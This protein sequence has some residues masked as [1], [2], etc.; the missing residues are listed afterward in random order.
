MAALLAKLKVK[1]TLE[2]RYPVGIVMPTENVPP[3]IKAITENKIKDHTVSRKQ[4][5]KR[6]KTKIEKKLPATDKIVAERSSTVAPDYKPAPD[7]SNKKVVDTIAKVFEI[8]LPVKRKYKLILKPQDK[9]TPNLTVKERITVKP[10]D[11]VQSGPTSMIVI[12]DVPLKK[13]LPKKRE[14]IGIKVS[15]YYMNNREI[16]INFMSSLF[17]KYKD[18]ATAYREDATCDYD[19]NAPFSLMPHQKI[20]RDYINLITPYRG[21]LL[22]HGLGSGKTCS[23][24]A[25]AEGMKDSRQIYILTP[26]SL[27]SNYISELKKCGDSLYR[28]NQF[29]EFINTVDNPG[30]IDTLSF[31]LKLNET[32]INKQ[33]GVWLVNVKK[34][35]N[36]EILTSEEK[37]SL[38]AQ[39]DQMI[40]YKYKFL[41]Y[42]G[43][44]MSHLQRLTKNFTVNPFDDGVIIIDEAHNFIS[45]I[46]NKLGKKKDGVSIRMYEYLLDAKNAKVVLLTGTPIINYPNEIAILF[47]ILRGKIKSWQLKLNIKKSKKISEKYFKDLFK[48]AYPENNVVDYINYKSSSTTLVITRNPFGFVNKMKNDK[49]K[50]VHIPKKDNQKKEDNLGEVEKTLM[51]VDNDKTD[52]NGNLTDESFI[53]TISDLLKAND[54]DILSVNINTYKALPDT[55]DDFKAYFID[56]ENKVENMGL[57]KRRIL[58]LT[59]YFRS[60]QESLLPKYSYASNFHLI[61]VKMSQ[62]QFKIYEEARVSERKLEVRNARKRK[63]Q[64]GGIYEESVST[65]RIFSR[66]FCNFVFPKPDIVRPLPSKDLDLEEAIMLEGADEDLLDAADAKER[67]QNVDGRYDEEDIADMVDYVKNEIAEE[68]ESEK[69][70]PEK[71]DSQSAVEPDTAVEK[72]K[73]LVEEKVDEV[74]DLSESIMASSKGNA[75]DYDTR[76]KRALAKLD[77]NKEKYLTPEPLKTYSPK[78]LYMLENIQDEDHKGLHLIYSQFR[79]LEGIGIIKLVLEANGYAQFRIKE[80]GRGNWKLNIP[81]EDL[82][83][84]MFAL[85]TGTETAEEKEVIRNIFNSSWKYVP[86]SLAK[87]L[88]AISDN[89]MYGEIIK[90]LMIT[91][92]GSEGINLRN[93]RYVHL[94]EPYWHPVRLQQV[95]GRARRICSHQDLP[96]EERTVDVFLYLMTFSPDQLKSDE[97]IEL[98]L[99]DKSKIDNKTPVTTDESLYEI[100]SIKEGITNQLLTA[101][102]ESAIDCALHSRVGDDEDLKCMTFGNVSSSK[103]SY[104]PSIS[105]EEADDIA[106]KNQK[107]DLLDAIE[108]EVDGKKYAYDEK[109]QGL[110][111]FEEYKR[112]QVVKVADITIEDD[113]Y[114]IA[115]L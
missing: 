54:I 43:L 17:G 77:K 10:K 80:D 31:T 51:D 50:G 64:K 98:R 45:R 55:L 41:N 67:L 37:A 69:G 96:E 25:I 47:N 109:T 35:S 57:F 52:D 105:T 74:V 6:V 107:L 78:F 90:V 75:G 33:G 13:R 26:A 73:N 42:N 94:T 71:V 12:N 62:F 38:D 70:E 99:H 87:E 76:I 104:Q 103:F 85:Y 81:E 30:L 63:A 61:K 32:F 59:S 92:S 36:F 21:I 114:N 101:V 20:V 83:K 115:Y 53:K 110:Y 2:E 60:A 106:D 29:W 8:P 84:P 93:V 88:A 111:D 89:N 27:R 34:E 86:T 97:S 91:A 100:A 79:T 9:A 7:V 15:S 3:E 48:N 39:L 24:I 11:I 65:Y 102:K 4:F 19:D 66:A 28:K 112:N 68:K 1:D 95:I 16:F 14:N 5:L 72:E 82:G 18:E 108:L 46:V 49:Y 44:R 58:G 56:K 113:K 40:S 22:Y 23:S